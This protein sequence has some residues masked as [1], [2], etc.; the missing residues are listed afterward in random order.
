MKQSY[1]VVPK[2]RMY[3]AAGSSSFDSQSV[4]EA[5]YSDCVGTSV[6]NVPCLYKSG[7]SGDPPSTVV[8]YVCSTEYF[9]GVSQVTV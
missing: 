4:E 8:H 2:E 5:I 7:I 6:D 9:Q 3:F 1:F